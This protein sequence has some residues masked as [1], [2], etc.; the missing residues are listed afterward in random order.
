MDH[1]PGEE[2]VLADRLSRW[3]KHEDTI[4]SL[5]PRRERKLSIGRVLDPVWK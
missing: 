1:L 2:N 4:R 3:R 5:D